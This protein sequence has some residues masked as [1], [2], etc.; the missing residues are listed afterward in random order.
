MLTVMMP[1]VLDLTTPAP[2]GEPSRFRCVAVQDERVPGI[3][4]P[5]E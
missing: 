5:Q 2:D 1:I 3:A 4:Q